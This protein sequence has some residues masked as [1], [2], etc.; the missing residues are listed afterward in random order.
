MPVGGIKSLACAQIES[1]SASV[2][3]YSPVN[4]EPRSRV[5][6]PLR[7]SPSRGN[8]TSPVTVVSRASSASART[9]LQ[10]ALNRPRF[11]ASSFRV[12]SANIVYESDNLLHPVALSSVT[13]NR[14]TPF[15]GRVRVTST[16]ETFASHA[17]ATISVSKKNL[18]FC[19]SDLRS[20]SRSISNQLLFV[21]MVFPLGFGRIAGSLAQRCVV[22]L[23]SL[24]GSGTHDEISRTMLPRKPAH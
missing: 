2:I 12:D 24:G 6:V 11:V 5:A 3:S 7:F 13:V 16:R 4:S 22:V 10:P 9:S 19:A 8:I 15:S 18:S 14:V 17:F 23:T 20:P 1:H 21:V